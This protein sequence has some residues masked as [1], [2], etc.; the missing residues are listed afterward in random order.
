VERP[1][2]IVDD[3][4]TVR[5]MIADLLTGLRFRVLEAGSAERAVAMA[6][7]I[8]IGAFL[9]DVQ[10]RGASGLDVCRAVRQMDEYKASPIIIITG[11]HE[12][13]ILLE[14]FA[15][16][17]DDFINKPIDGVVLLA[18]LRALLQR[19]EY[20]EELERTRRMLNRYL[21]TRTREVA[22]ASTKTGEMPAPEQRDLVIL[23]TDLRGFTALSEELTPDE[24]FRQVSS[25][26]EDQVDLVYEYGGYVDKFGGDGVMAVFD[27]SDRVRQSC[28]CALRMIE[29]AQRNATQDDRIRQLAIGIHAGNA[30]IGN[31]G[32][33]DHMDYSVIG[34][35]V[36]LAAR[37]CGHAERMSI[38]VSEAIKNAASGDL[39]LNFHSGRMVSIRGLKDQVMVYSLSERRPL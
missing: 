3:E 13:D 31:I 34:T 27:K 6:R 30:V 29:K 1:I 15:A 19:M 32:S 4:P 10:L 39:R 37:L 23:F 17:C 22:E 28:L 36:N 11:L 21:S 26:L 18:R 9:V 33:A 12:R 24:L 8:P 35:N 38:V 7:E 16:G 2:L 5:A 25:Q 14:A 20:F